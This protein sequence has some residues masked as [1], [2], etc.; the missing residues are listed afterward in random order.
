M[1]K[2]HLLTYL[3]KQLNL[4]NAP[5]ALA[6]ANAPLYYY[7][8]FGTVFRRLEYILCE[9]AWQNMFKSNAQAAFYC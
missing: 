5:A 9:R 6:L 2:P 8:L 7:R 1:E 4:T 3:H